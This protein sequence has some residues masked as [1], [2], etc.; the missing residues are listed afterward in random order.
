ANQQS[1][2]RQLTDL[3]RAPEGQQ[4]YLRQITKNDL[5][6]PLPSPLVSIQ[7]YCRKSTAMKKMQEALTHKG[8]TSAHRIT[9]RAQDLFEQIMRSVTADYMYTLLLR[10]SILDLLTF[11]IDQQKI[12]FTQSARCQLDFKDCAWG[13]ALPQDTDFRVVL[14]PKEE[15]TQTVSPETSML[16]Q[17][18]FKMCDPGMIFTGSTPVEDGKTDTPLLDITAHETQERC[19]SSNVVPFEYLDEQYALKRKVNGEDLDT[20][21]WQRFV[22]K[23][24]DNLALYILTDDLETLD[25]YLH[26]L[27]DR[28]KALVTDSFSK[29]Q[30]FNENHAS[31]PDITKA[32]MHKVL[33]EAVLCK[34]LFDHYKAKDE[35]KHNT[36][37]E[38]LV[39]IAPYQTFINLKRYVSVVNP[40]TA[41]I[42]SCC[43]F[44]DHSPQHSA[45]GASQTPLERPL[46]LMRKAH[47][48]MSTQPAA[49]LQLY[50]DYLDQA[51]KTR[52]N[53]TSEDAVTPDIKNAVLLPLTP[54]EEALAYVYQN[55]LELIVPESTQ[56]PLFA[57]GTPMQNIAYARNPKTQDRIIGI[58][59]DLLLKLHN[60]KKQGG[61]Y[62]KGPSTKYTAC[63]ERTEKHPC[64][65]DSILSQPQSGPKSI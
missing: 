41:P 19:T 42:R 48:Q 55:L 45:N 47:Y 21:I 62:T 5:P 43:T 36:F 56:G 65:H 29:I 64:I 8:F 16:L 11:F 27:D 23:I 20:T 54:Q 44:F 25:T 52:S 35:E 51:Y 33:K 38:R 30:D 40:D 26:Q 17:E 4:K 7:N 6:S 63:I 32:I 58:A 53:V 22:D 2:L 13:K 34:I 37:N 10:A 14:P 50:G 57:K 46:S 1:Y 39:E 31:C 15:L 61:C 24:K 28:Q 18:T 60:H 59:D 3:S 12:C 9:E 49:L